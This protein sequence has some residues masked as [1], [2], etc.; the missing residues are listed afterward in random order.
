M[1][2]RL[3]HLDVQRWR[4]P[5][6]ECGVHSVAGPRDG[7][8]DG[9]R[10]A[11]FLLRQRERHARNRPVGYSACVEYKQRARS[12]IPVVAD[13]QQVP[14]I[15]RGAAGPWREADLTA[16]L[17]RARQPNL[18]IRGASVSV[19]STL[20]TGVTPSAFDPAVVYTKRCRRPLTDNRAIDGYSKW[21]VE[22]A[23]REYEPLFRSS[24]YG[25]RSVRGASRSKSM[26]VR[27]A[28]V[29]P[30]HALER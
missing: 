19:L 8:V 12:R 16:V 6:H 11:A 4:Q 15:L 2:L 17:E 14:V 10:L 23:R 7:S 29:C 5:R 1:V 26:S 22:R 20:A 9:Q 18:R 25:T 30:L 3:L 27:I 28:F 24:V 21:R 13:R